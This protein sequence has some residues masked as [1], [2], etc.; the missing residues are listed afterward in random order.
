MNRLFIVLFSLAVLRI[1]A[2]EHRNAVQQIVA[3][4]DSFT[5]KLPAE[6]LFVHLDKPY[7]V[8]GD[9]I[10]F[11]AYLL[12]A[13]TL[14]YSN[15]SGLL[16]VELISS[17][18]K[19]IKRT[20]WPVSF[21]SSW[22][23]LALESNLPQ[24][25]Y[26]LRAYTNWMQNFGEQYFFQ[27]QFAVG[28]LADNN[29]LI[30]E[31]HKTDAS[32]AEMSLN[33]HLNNTL[34]KPIAAKDL[35]L[36]ILDGSQAVYKHDVQTSRDGSVS[37]QFVLPA[38]LKSSSLLAT[39]TDKANAKK[40]SVIPLPLQRPE[41]TDLQFMPEGGYL[42]AGLPSV[43]A[44]KA[45]AEN[46]LGTNVEGTVVDKEGKEVAR[47]RS[48][49]EGMGEFELTPVEG[50]KYSALLKLPNGEEKRYPL[51][52]VKSSGVVLRVQQRKNDSLDLSLF[53]SPS[54]LGGNVYHLV[55]LSRGVVCYA[56][57]VQLN[58]AER[59]SKIAESRFPTGIAHFALFDEANRPLVERIVFINHKD[60]LHLQINPSAKKYFPHDS[61]ALNIQVTDS[62][63]QPVVGSFSV[64]VTDDGQVKQENNS[65]ILS[66]MLLTPDLKGTVEYP[67]YYFANS[68]ATAL[69]LLML[70]QGWTGYDWPQ[71]FKGA[72][73]PAFA[74]EPSFS[75]KGKITNLVNGAAKGAKVILMSTGEKQWVKD[76][77]ANN[78]GRFIF[79]NFP[80][81]DKMAFVVQATNAK[82][83]RFGIGVE[84]A[85]FTPP[86]LPQTPLLPK[87]PWYVNSDSS[88]VRLAQNSAALFKQKR[89]LSP[90]ASL[91]EEVF[92]KTKKTVRGSNNLNGAGEADEVLDATDLEAMG[93]KTLEDILR[94][95]IKGFQIRAGADGR[96]YAINNQKI[97]LRV[98]GLDLRK[99]GSSAD[100]FI[101][102]NSLTAED[103][104]GI[105][106]M[107][108]GRFNN[109]Y[110]ANILSGPE[111]FALPSRGHAY[112][113]ITTRSGNGYFMK[114]SP[115]LAVYK[116]VPVSWPRQ[117][118]RPVY[119]PGTVNN[120]KDLRSTI[121]WQPNVVTDKSG[122]AVVSFYAAD[123]PGTYSVIVQGGD[124]NGSVGYGKTTVTISPTK[125]F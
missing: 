96:T 16:Y 45:V 64:S 110:N 59:F 66:A 56:A 6:K 124:M 109:R 50:E 80:V 54:L 52:T 112:I 105:E 81:N 51:P 36:Q 69:D 78:E 73:S 115:G 68:D 20:S 61:I 8:V 82:G 125:S 31:S 102:N 86:Q 76:T 88:D 75:V 77:V 95:N 39:L 117:F 18:D 34:N 79:S 92:I 113:E 85:S 2:Q 11:K 43:V 19:L 55:G 24:G 4:V 57:N 63:Q 22:G 94:E 108:S 47:F 74:A 107:H 42:V 23:Q 17:D 99:V 44:F 9:T 21:G 103:I 5:K 119:T 71:I 62:Q 111:N 58:K 100:E 41:K 46:G 84:M 7:Y 98:D 106:V 70:T 37:E 27:Q 48:A 35:S 60:Q 83:K 93:A 40:T 123:A 28:S 87:R 120:E 53:F 49:H 90:D 30:T 101:Y 116:P 15:T 3:S 26:L 89:G 12:D 72:V 10:W 67:A 65:N 104:I 25:T 14:A 91:M 32:G 33:L 121:H 122:R 29:W 114:N 38:N 118:Y 1:S 97:F 13:S